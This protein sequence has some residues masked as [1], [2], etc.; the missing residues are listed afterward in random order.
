MLLKIL[1]IKDVKAR[2]LADQ[3]RLLQD[4]VKAHLT[5]LPFQVTLFVHVF[6][7]MIYRLQAPFINK[8][9][10]FL[11]QNLT[12]FGQYKPLDRETPT[13]HDILTANFRG[14]GGLCGH[15]NICLKYQLENIGY[16]VSQLSGEFVRTGIPGSHSLIAVHIP[17]RVSK[18]KVK[19]DRSFLV[20]VGCGIPLAEPVPLDE[21]PYRSRAGGLDFRYE[22]V[23][24]FTV[25]RVNECGD[26]IIG[27]V[28][29]T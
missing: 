7:I 3:Y 4:I 18:E 16:N 20:D 26:A 14:G 8:L 24:D 5:R 28:A 23:D 21:L 12:S 1:N 29:T 11:F 10:S 17:G 6:I 2:F 9:V 13:L 25:R 22:K 19:R 15:L 27:K